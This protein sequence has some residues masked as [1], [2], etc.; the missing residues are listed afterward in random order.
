MFWKPKEFLF[1]IQYP[2]H[3]GVADDYFTYE[4][5]QSLLKN[6]SKS[7]QKRRACGVCDNCSKVDCGKC[8]H[9]K[10]M[11]KYGGENILRQ[12]CIKRFCPFMK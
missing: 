4:E 5:L 3:V 8:K 9:C 6:N 2:K 1:E 10:D 11:R 12:K 7:K